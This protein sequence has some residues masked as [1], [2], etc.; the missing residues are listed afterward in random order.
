M[1][2]FPIGM[3]IALSL[4]SIYYIYL[5]YGSVDWQVQATAAYKRA[6]SDEDKLQG[7]QTTTG[8]RTG[9]GLSER[10]I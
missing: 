8:Y 4:L 9:S 5:I 7:L 1:L 3:I 2:A 10:F 6:I